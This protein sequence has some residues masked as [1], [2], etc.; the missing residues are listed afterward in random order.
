[1]L[2]PGCSS[3]GMYEISINFIIQFEECLLSFIIETINA[4]LDCLCLV[5]KNIECFD[6]VNQTASAD[7][8]FD[9]TIIEKVLRMMSPPSTRRLQKSGATTLRSRA[10]FSRIFC[11]VFT[12]GY[13]CSKVTGNR[14][15]KSSL[16]TLVPMNRPSSEPLPLVFAVAMT[17]NP[18]EGRTN[19]PIFLR[20]TPFPSRMLWRQR[21]LL[22]A[23]SISSRSRIA[24]RSSASMTG[25]LCQTVAPST[26]RSR[27]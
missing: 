27:Q 22:E 19:R 10:T 3:S 23:R 24:P 17:L 11:S 6:D 5:F 26:R 9:A 25:P 18:A 13:S 1:M 12:E 7:N 8:F 21:I 15:R 14:S 2:S 4:D 20:K 16:S